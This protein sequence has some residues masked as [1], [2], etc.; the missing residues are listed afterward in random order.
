MA[1]EGIGQNARDSTVARSRIEAYVLQHDSKPPSP[2][3]MRAMEALLTLMRREGPTGMSMRSLARELSIKPASIYS[4]F[5]GGKD[6]LLEV[7]LRW[8]YSKFLHT[9]LARVP[10]GASH[11]VELQA[12]IA[13]QLDYQLKFQHEGTW[14]FLFETVTGEKQAVTHH[15]DVNEWRSL[16]LDYVEAVALSISPIP[17]ARARSWAMVSFLNDSLSFV[18]RFPPGTPDS[19][20]YKEATLCCQRLLGL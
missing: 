7:T 1:S 20:I 8:S 10:S 15:D 9:V 19:T 17:F 13:G 5:E 18:R 16:Y 3:R 2:G 12:I 11:M 14:Q 4:L 6:E